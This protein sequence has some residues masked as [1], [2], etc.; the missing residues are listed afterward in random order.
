[1][2]DTILMEP[3]FLK[4]QN[5]QETLKCSEEQLCSK[6]SASQLWLQCTATDSAL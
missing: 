2:P 3:M 5:V 1:M 4:N 6:N